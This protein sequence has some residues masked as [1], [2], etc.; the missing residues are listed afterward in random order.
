LIGGG[1]I[2]VSIYAPP[3]GNYYFGVTGTVI[4]VFQSR[5]SLGAN[6]RGATN[7]SSRLCCFNPPALLV[8]GAT[9]R[10]QKVVI[11]R[12]IFQSTRKNATQLFQRLALEL[13]VPIHAPMESATVA[14]LERVHA[15]H[16]HPRACK[17]RDAALARI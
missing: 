12:F 8:S 7:A 5:A 1:V 15:M 17:K 2:A 16:F 10:E 3:R 4:K 9:F 11:D 6:G 13:G 14:A